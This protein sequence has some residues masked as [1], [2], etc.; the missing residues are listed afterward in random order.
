MLTPS[1]TAERSWPYRLRRMSTVS[2]AGARPLGSV[3]RVAARIM[4]E[5]RA[6]RAA[7]QLMALDERMLRDIGLERSEIGHAVRIGTVWRD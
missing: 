3:A 4:L 1:I 7:R 6:R 5:Y 2:A